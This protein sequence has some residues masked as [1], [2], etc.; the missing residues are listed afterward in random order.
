MNDEPETE[1]TVGATEFDLAE[2]RRDAEELDDSASAWIR[3]NDDPHD[4]DEEDYR[5]WQL[6]HRLASFA[7]AMMDPT[8][9]SADEVR[10]AVEMEPW[11][12]GVS[13]SDGTSKPWIAENYRVIIRSR[14]DLARLRL[15]L[16][17]GGK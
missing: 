1:A 8:P 2:L 4:R 17:A 9:V 10:S 15:G 6:Q 14:G 12:D 16:R 7:L 5:W 11:Y 3:E 13:Y